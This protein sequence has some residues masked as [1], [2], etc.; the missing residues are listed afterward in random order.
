MTLR[1]T[2]GFQTWRTEQLRV[3]FRAV[4]GAGQFPAIV[5][6]GTAFWRPPVR[7]LVRAVAATVDLGDPLVAGG[8]PPATTVSLGVM[9]NGAGVPAALIAANTFAAWNTA[10]GVVRGWFNNTQVAA[11]TTFAPPGQEGGLVMHPA[12]Q[13]FPG[14]TQGERSIAAFTDNATGTGTGTML[15]VLQ[16]RPI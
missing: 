9:V 13:F 10:G 11:G 2:V 6:A 7:A 4:P 1:V 15:V 8:V 3:E 14:E 12:N 5:L 16:W